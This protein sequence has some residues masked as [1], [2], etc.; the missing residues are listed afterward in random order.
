MET[1]ALKVTREDGDYQVIVEHPDTANQE[2]VG[3]F[4][5][6]TDGSTSLAVNGRVDD[7][8]RKLFLAIFDFF[9]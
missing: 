3:Y 4:S 6:E 8:T 1:I 2:E 7:R 5:V 9:G